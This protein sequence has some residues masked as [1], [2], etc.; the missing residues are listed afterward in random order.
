MVHPECADMAAGSGRAGD[1]KPA[2][3]VSHV[4][5]DGGVVDGVASGCLK[6]E[7]NLRIKPLSVPRTTLNLW[8]H[9]W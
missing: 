5:V 6:E 8:A 2:V 4:D 3:T 9:W 7:F 1:L